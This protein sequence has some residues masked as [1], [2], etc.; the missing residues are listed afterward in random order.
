MDP[1]GA[2]LFGGDI[3]D[4]ILNT[5]NVEIVGPF[6][7]ELILGTVSQNSVL[8]TNETNRITQLIQESFGYSF[9]PTGVFTVTW[10]SARYVFTD[11]VSVYISSKLDDP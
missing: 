10:D 11:T 5:E 4:F 6:W 2:I 1:G 8:N 3:K 9:V 7:A